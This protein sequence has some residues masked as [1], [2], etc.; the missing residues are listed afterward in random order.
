M[1]AEPLAVE[2]LGSGLTEERARKIFRMGEAVV[3]FALLAQ[4]QELAWESPGPKPSPT[5]RSGAVPPYQKPD[6]PK[7][8]RKKPGRKPGHAGARRAR[9]EHVD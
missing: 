3:V 7:K 2:Q 6:K 8:R 9:P 4:A 1:T 5:T